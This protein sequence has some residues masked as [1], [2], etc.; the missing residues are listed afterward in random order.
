MTRVYLPQIQADFPS[1]NYEEFK[2]K[3]E[4]MLASAFSAISSGKATTLKSASDDLKD[5]IALTI[6]ENSR[7]GRK[8]SYDNV[9]IYQTE[10][11]NYKKQSGTCVITLQ[12]AVSYKHY[13][14]ENGITIEGSRTMVEQTKYNTELVYIQDLAKVGSDYSNAMGTNCPNCGAPITNLGNKTCEYCQMAV[15][16]IN[17]YVWSI[18]SFNKI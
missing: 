9:K 10:I 12:S 8:E 2:N 6:S 16:E 11:T 17:A 4:I 1:F 3:A 5:K 7:Q 14:E 18:S 15:M 13:I